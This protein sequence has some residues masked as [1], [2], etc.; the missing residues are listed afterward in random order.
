MNI[1]GFVRKTKNSDTNEGAEHNR[2]PN[3]LN[4]E[5]KAN[6]PMQKIVTDVTYIENNSK[7]YYLACNMDL[8]NNEIIDYELG[9]KFDN[10]LVMKPARRI[11]EK[12]KNEY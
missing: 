2:Y 3:I 4:R 5:F 8:F 11:L 12:A 1:T 6:K 10:Y 7:W 9:D